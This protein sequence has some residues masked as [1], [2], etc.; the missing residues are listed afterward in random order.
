MTSIYQQTS[1]SQATREVAMSNG[2]SSANTAEMTWKPPCLTE[3]MK[4]MIQPFVKK[5]N[6]WIEGMTQVN[7][8]NRNS[9]LTNL[10]N[11]KSKCP[12]C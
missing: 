10:A 4:T 12:L 5:F 6:Q 1:L 8:D 7:Q 2:L 9:F 11:L 3:D